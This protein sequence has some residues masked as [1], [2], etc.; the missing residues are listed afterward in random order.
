MID[1]AADAE[2]ENLLFVPGMYSTGHTG[3]DLDSMVAGMRRAV[4]CGRS[5]NIPIL[6]EDFDGIFSPYNSIAGLQYFF[7]EIP[8]LECAFDTGN[9]AMFREDELQ[10]FELFADR[11]RTVHLKDRAAERRHEG[12]T[13][14]VCADG[15]S[16]YACSIGTGYIRIGEILRRLRERNY[17]GNVVIELY[18]CDTKHVI[19]DAFDSLHQVREW[20]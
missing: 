11:I 9:F 8:G 13:P 17:G 6:M 15:K 4:D 7:R 2:A 18:A 14:F 3:R 1:L 10:A 19:Q 16:V 20:I 12:D 5:R